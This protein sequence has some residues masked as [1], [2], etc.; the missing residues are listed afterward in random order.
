MNWT[1]K[2]ERFVN[3]IKTQSIGY[4]PAA[5]RMVIVCCTMA[6]SGCSTNRPL[7]AGNKAGEAVAATEQTQAQK[8]SERLAQCQK[9]LDVLKGINAGQ[10]ATYKQE[11]ER[12]M[13]G[14]AQYAGVRPRVNWETQ[15]TVD[16][17][18]R[19]KVNRLCA[20]IIQAA[21]TGLAERGEHLK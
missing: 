16:A 20:D 18:Y 8:E 10:Y 3:R 4:L 5:C 1:M 12:L 11:F 14:A 6:M 2:R 15:E 7:P 17:L 21:L 13:S 19:Y 9:E